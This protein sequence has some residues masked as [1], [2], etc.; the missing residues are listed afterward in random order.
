MARYFFNRT[1][2]VQDPDNEGVELYDLD[3][4]RHEAFLFAID[5]LRDSRYPLWDGGVFRVEVSDSSRTVIFSIVISTN[6]DVPPRDAI[7]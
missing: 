6:L 7:S 3:H 5:T 2:D 1:G 4:A